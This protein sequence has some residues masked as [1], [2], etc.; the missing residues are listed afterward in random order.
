MEGEELQGEKQYGIHR[1]FKFARKRNNKIYITAKKD[2]I[3]LESTNKAT[4]VK[5]EFTQEC[6]FLLLCNI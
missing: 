1:I 3:N 2:I 6:C 5:V 4:V